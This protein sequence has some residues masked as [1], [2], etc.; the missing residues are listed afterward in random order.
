LKNIYILYLEEDEFVSLLRSGDIINY[1]NGELFS[2]S[3][4]SRKIS[5]M[6]YWKKW[7]VS[8]K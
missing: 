1:I 7:H 5:Q 2:L 8:V 6:S 4:Q 3:C